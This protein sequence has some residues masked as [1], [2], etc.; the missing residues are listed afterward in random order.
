VRRHII[1]LVAVSVNTLACPATNESAAERSAVAVTAS[2]L[3]SDCQRMRGTAGTM[4]PDVV[5]P[6]AVQAKSR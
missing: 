3:P 5:T 6:A 4:D 2:G 1:D